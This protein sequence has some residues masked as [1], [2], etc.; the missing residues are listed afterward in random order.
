MSI[1]MAAKAQEA[2]RAWLSATFDQRK[3]DSTKIAK[4]VLAAL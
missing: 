2:Q 3:A 4:L 1:S